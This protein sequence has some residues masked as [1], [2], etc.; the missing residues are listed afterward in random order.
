MDDRGQRRRFGI[1]WMDNVALTA[2]LSNQ[3]GRINSLAG[4]AL[5]FA[6]ER[7]FLW[8]DDITIYNHHSPALAIASAAQTWLL[9]NHSLLA[10]A[11]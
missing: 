4:I 1:L 8:S 6:D 10:S 11:I 5:A 3:D 9:F 7:N 2:W